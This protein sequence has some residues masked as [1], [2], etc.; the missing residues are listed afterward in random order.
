MKLVVSFMRNDVQLFAA[1]QTNP[2]FSVNAN[3]TERSFF[4]AYKQTIA[5]ILRFVVT[6]HEK[7]AQIRMYVGLA[8]LESTLLQDFF[9]V[10]ATKF[11]KRQRKLERQKKIILQTQEA[12][13]YD[14]KNY[15]YSEG[16]L[17]DEP[18]LD[19]LRLVTADMRRRFDSMKT[20]FT[21]A[22]GAFLKMLAAIARCK[23]DAH[24]VLVKYKQ[25]LVTDAEAI[26]NFV[27]NLCLQV[28]S[29]V[30]LRS[31]HVKNEMTTLRTTLTADLVAHIRRKKH[32]LADANASCLEISRLFVEY[33]IM[34][35]GRVQTL[36]DCVAE[37]ALAV[38]NTVLLVDAER[39]YYRNVVQPKKLRS[40][41]KK[42]LKL[43]EKHK[44]A[45]ESLPFQ[46]AMAENKKTLV[47]LSIFLAVIFAFAAFA[48]QQA[49]FNERRLFFWKW[50]KD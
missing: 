20:D 24:D 8:A 41:P 35:E 5:S 11:Q 12:V 7:L 42:F 45:I 25:F 37:C 22:R 4:D 49:F 10:E 38:E 48:V 32:L 14:I 13:H 3:A 40:T 23:R 18:F 15:G 27:H 46:M 19:Q 26:E 47:I 43:D 31:I 6:A 21:M 44:F 29:V 39:F 33:Q 9:Y 28:P 16:T 34:H 17:Y 50:R 2:G 36:A 30:I 1:T